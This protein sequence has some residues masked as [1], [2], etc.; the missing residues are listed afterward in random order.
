MSSEEEEDEEEEGW[1]AESLHFTFSSI[2]TGEHLWTP[3]VLEN[4][5]TVFH[6][7]EY[8]PPVPP[9]GQRSRE[10]RDVT[11]FASIMIQ[12][13]SLTLNN[14][15]SQTCRPDSLLTSEHFVKEY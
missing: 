6:V 10:T 7:L 5:V 9:R 3:G 15:S 2:L 8:H 12:C 13:F 14:Q 1:S 11:F 4:T